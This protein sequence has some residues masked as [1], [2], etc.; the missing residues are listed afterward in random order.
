[1]TKGAREYKRYYTRDIELSID[2]PE[3]ELCGNPMDAMGGAWLER[4]A[5]FVQVC[6]VFSCTIKHCENHN[7]PREH[8][9]LLWD[10]RG[11][12]DPKNHVEYID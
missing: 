9:N 5:K 11:L 3:C 2:R 10:F 6:R 4:G 7:R 1:M 12:T 8:R